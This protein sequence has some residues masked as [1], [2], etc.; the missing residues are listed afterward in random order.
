[1]SW[2]VLSSV[3]VERPPVTVHLWRRWQRVPG[4]GSCNWK[5]TVTR[6]HPAYILY[7][8][9]SLFTYVFSINVFG[10]V[11]LSQTH[12]GLRQENCDERDAQ[13]VAA[14]AV[15]SRYCTSVCI[16]SAVVATDL[17]DQWPLTTRQSPQWSW[18][19]R[20]ILMLIAAGVNLPP[21][22]QA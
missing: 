9:N 8:P 19:G 5:R 1:M 11:V 13:H 6:M 20:Q 3:A 7:Q 10:G 21:S 16:C 15:T 4:T 18:W 22:Q 12:Y 14:A 2:R 17:H